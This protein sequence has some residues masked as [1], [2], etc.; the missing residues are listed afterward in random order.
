MSKKLV[1]ICIVI[2]D[3]YLLTKYSIQNL[4]DKTDISNRLYILDNACEDDKL[5]NYAKNVCRE[6]N[7]YYNRVDKPV[8]ITESLNTLLRVVGQEYCC[9][10]PANAI[11]YKNWLEDLITSQ[12]TV[13][14]LGVSAIR[15]YMKNINF[16]PVLKQGLNSEEDDLENV[17]LNKTNT[18]ENVMLFKTEMLKD[19]GEYD[20]D[21]KADGYEND[22]FCFRFSS[23]GLK[24]IYI[25]NQVAYRF[26]SDNRTLYPIKTEEGAKA[27]QKNIE[28]MLVSGI[29]KKG[30]YGN[31]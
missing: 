2:Q 11:V 21:L 27:F 13:Y 5:S 18:V 26:H 30:S 22:E 31:P 25:R 4:L 14:D 8:S 19:V 24:N 20:V 28:G 7:G 16:M 3:E 17:I 9:V 23:R 12:E 29:K 10:F 1:A 15:Q 6:S